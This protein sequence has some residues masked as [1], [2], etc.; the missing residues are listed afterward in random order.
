VNGGVCI[1]HGAKVEKK[2]CS[3]VGCTNHVQNGG[4][5]ITHGAKNSV[6]NAILRDVPTRSGR[7][8]F[9]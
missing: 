5:C 2:L 4:V 3:F 1:T 6:N 7:E 9:V 8:E